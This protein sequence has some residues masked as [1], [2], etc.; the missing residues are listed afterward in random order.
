MRGGRRRACIAVAMIVCDTV[1]GLRDALDRIRNRTLRE[2]RAA[3]D[4]AANANGTAAA[5]EQTP[6]EPGSSVSVGLVATMGYLHDGH[7][8]LIAQSRHENDVTVGT[9]FVNRKQFERDE[10]FELYPRDQERDC[11]LFEVNGADVVFAPHS[12]EELYPQGHETTISCQLLSKRSEGRNR[13]GHFD[14][15]A[16]IVAKLF[17]LIQPQNAYFGAKDAQQCAIIKRMTTDLNFATRVRI[18]ETVRDPSDGLALSSR[19]AMLTSHER[20]Y[21][22]TLYRSLCAASARMRLSLLHLDNGRSLEFL[23]RPE[24]AKRVMYRI[25]SDSLEASGC[26]THIDDVSVV[27]QDTF[28]V[29][30]G[31]DTKFSCALILIAVYL[32]KARLIDNVRVDLESRDQQPSQTEADVIAGF[33]IAD[34]SEEEMSVL[35][36]DYLVL[37]YGLA[38]QL[39]EDQNRTKRQRLETTSS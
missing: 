15:V 12:H 16:L 30:D 6:V 24:G 2:K 7:A 1:S 22:N 19:N 3:R 35:V 25:L 29:M 27:N 18:V 14:G 26:H 4:A 33:K 11:V 8:A 21:A 5:S 23:R 9:I 31:H 38:R 39:R 28:E 32:G 34:G 36:D 10:D 37:T 13:P 20:K 17:I